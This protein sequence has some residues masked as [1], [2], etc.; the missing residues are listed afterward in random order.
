[1]PQ[2]AEGGPKTYVP[3]IAD[4]FGDKLAAGS[5]KRKGAKKPPKDATTRAGDVAMTA[6]QGALK[7]CFESARATDPSQSVTLAFEHKPKA[8]RH[9]MCVRAVRESGRD[10]VT[11]AMTDCMW[12]AVAAWAKSAP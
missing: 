1:V 2:Q 6:L 9:E 10:D 12:N 5:S 4:P 8:G 7:A 11:K 3:F